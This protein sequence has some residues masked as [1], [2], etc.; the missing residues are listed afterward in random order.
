LFCFLLVC[1]FVCFYFVLFIIIIII[2]FVMHPVSIVSCVPGLS[3]LGCPIQFSL[4]NHN[5][6]L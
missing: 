1:L 3:I 5:T 6:E 4:I 2:F